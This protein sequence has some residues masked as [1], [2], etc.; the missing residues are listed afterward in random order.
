MQVR[1]YKRLHV[2]NKSSIILSFSYRMEDVLRVY[3]KLDIFIILQITDLKDIPTL[4]SY[5]LTVI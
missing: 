2:G 5:S 1:H 3:L 4:F